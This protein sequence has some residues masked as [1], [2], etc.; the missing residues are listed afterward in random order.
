MD[1]VCE[2]VVKGYVLIFVVDGLWVM[3]ENLL[4]FCGIWDLM[5]VYVILGDIGELKFL[6][7]MFVVVMKVSGLLDE[8]CG[9]VVMVG[10]NLFCDIKGVNDFGLQS[11][12]V[13]WLKWCI[14]VVVDLFEVLDVCIDWLD[15]LVQMIEVMELVLD[16]S[17]G[18]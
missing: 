5:Q 4:K 15:Y 8:D 13:G 10:N 17:G 18:G 1:V 2:L 14:Y 11:F 3:F 9:C 6:F 7:K 16:I 12:F